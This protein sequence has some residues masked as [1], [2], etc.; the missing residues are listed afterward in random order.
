MML[1]VSSVKVTRNNRPILD[2]IDCSLETGKLTAMVGPNGAGKTTLLRVMSGSLQPHTGTVELAGRGIG[3]WPP[4]ELARTR[5]VLAQDVSLQFPFKVREVVLLGRTPH[6]KGFARREDYRIVDAALDRV[7]MSAFAFRD[8]TS[9]SGGEKQRVQIARALVQIEAA[10]PGQPRVLLLDEPVSALDLNFQHEV[11]NLARELAREGFAVAA[12]LHDLNLTLDY[13]DHVLALH[14]GRLAAEGPPASVLTPGLIKQLYGVEARYSVHGKRPHLR[15]RRLPPSDDRI[16][17]F[18]K[19]TDKPIITMTDT[20]ATPTTSPDDMLAEAAEQYETLLQTKKSVILATVNSAGIPDASYA[21]AIRDSDNRFY[22]Y[23]SALSRHTSCLKSGRPVS[24]MVIEDEH[25]SVQ[26]FA[27]QRVTFTCHPE[28]IQRD[29]DEFNATLDRMH[30]DLGD[31]VD[32]LRQMIDFDLFRLSPSAGRLVTGFGR[33]FKLPGE[34]GTGD[35]GDVVRHQPGV[36]LP[37]ET[38]GADSFVPYRAGGFTNYRIRGV[39][40]NRV[41]LTIDGIRQPPQFNMSGGNGRDFFDPAVFSSVEILKGSGSTLHGSDALGGVIAFQ[42]RSLFESLIDSERPWIAGS[43]LTFRSLDNSL[44]AVIRGGWHGDPWFVTMVNA[45]TTGEEQANDK[46]KVPAN[47]REFERNHVLGKLTWSPDELHRVT[48]TG[49]QFR[50]DSNTE[51]NSA[52]RTLFSPAVYG[53][54]ST[55]HDK[56]SR[57]SVEY[58]HRPLNG[59]WDTF[60]S[61]LYVQEART[62]SR[63]RTL[64]NP[65]ADGPPTT[66]DRTDIIGF[67][68][69]ILGAKAEGS[70][71]AVFGEWLHTFV[72]GVEA[73]LEDAENTFLREDRKPVERTQNRPAFDPSD[74]VRA[75]VYFQD[76]MEAGR[77]L[78]QLGLR[79]GFYEIQPRQD[80]TFLDYK[81]IAGLNLDPASAYRNIALSPSLAAQ[82]EWRPGLNLWARYARGV[83]NPDLED[84]VGFFD[85]LGQF[86]QIPNPNLSE[87]SSH[88]FDLGIKFQNGT[89][90]L[91]ATAYYTAYRDFIGTRSFLRDGSEVVQQQNLGEVDIYGI[92]LDL[93]YRLEA[94]SEGLSGWRIGFRLNIAKGDNKTAGG[95][96]DTVDPATAVAYIGFSAPSDDWGLRLNILHRA[97]KEDPST[98]YLESGLFIPP[99]STTA[100]LTGWWQFLPHASLQ[101]T[102]RNLTDKRYWTWPNA[103]SVD[104]TFMEDPELGVRPARNLVVSL[105]WEL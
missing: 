51:V 60:D 2:G 76:M 62:R 21:P 102:L 44:Q 73:S 72:T 28:L 84:Y 47:P 39:E 92:E 61:S 83:R 95:G 66:R 46:G 24:L 98:A 103:D 55:A 88:A 74:L 91:E 18:I 101:I 13:S 16:L 69:R 41:L 48:V 100:D 23:V 56:R 93:D 86:Q 22:V 14:H 96:V 54:A 67:Q 38:A 3:D 104:H 58:A 34:G 97:R 8:F 90:T 9:L 17:P 70:R 68:H 6:F 50:R 75:D 10:K 25:A 20:N 99:A 42:T 85:H 63:T 45:Y 37:F 105:N 57:V 71:E 32:T 64:A 7:G 65:R 36:S 27:R 78:L 12:I 53:V 79:V 40:G 33:A 89:L 15:V 35:A 5:A 52:E 81:G 1:T 49:E 11:L 77:W 29:S 87:E 82:Y 30:Q 19:E 94:L 59:L 31:L 80:E 43:T 26:L 4:K